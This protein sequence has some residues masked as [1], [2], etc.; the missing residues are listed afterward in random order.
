MSYNSI[1]RSI[2][3]NF[4]NNLDILDKIVRIKGRWQENRKSKPVLSFALIFVLI[5]FGLIFAPNSIRSIP[6]RII[7]F[8]ANSYLNYNANFKSDSRAYSKYDYNVT[9]QNADFCAIFYSIQTIDDSDFRKNII[10]NMN[11]EYYLPLALFLSLTIALN[12]NC[13]SKIKRLIL[14]DFIILIYLIFKII[15]TAYDNYNYPEYAIME[16][17]GIFGSVVYYYNYFLNFAGAGPNFIIPVCVWFL[18]FIEDINNV[19]KR[20]IGN[21]NIQ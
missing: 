12:L 15:A 2:Y 5:F 16:L 3:F 19:F 8:C 11:L 10:I 6:N 4:G 7:I 21:S 17:K 20:Q 1:S 13:K 14:G 9:N 18:L